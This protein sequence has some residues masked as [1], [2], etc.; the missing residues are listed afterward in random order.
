MRDLVEIPGHY[1]RM[2]RD[3]LAALYSHH[4]LFHG[5]V[6][7][8]LAYSVDGHFHLSGTVH[9]TRKGIG[10]SHTEIIVAVGGDD[11][12]V[13]IRH[14][15]AEILYLRAVFAWKAI[16]CRVGDVDDCSSGLNHSLND[17]G[18]VLVFR[19]S[20]IFRIELHVFH[21]FFRILHCCDRPFEDILTVRIELVPDMVVGRADS[22]VDSLQ[23]GEVQGIGR[24]IYILLDSPGQCA[25][26]GFRHYL[27]DFHDGFEIT[28]TRN[29]ETALDDIHLHGF[30]LLGQFYLLYRIQL[31]AGN[32]FAV[33]QCSVKDIKFLIHDYPFLVRYPSLSAV[34][35]MI[36]D[37]VSGN[38][39]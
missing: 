16:S 8:P 25:N 6:S 10:G 1:V 13:D 17:T 24:G 23:P 34:P 3:I 35:A 29:R 38:G 2:H 33:P 19:P 22:R 28:G 37:A 14:M 32:L 30:K 21:I 9:D 39:S 15:V 31:T 20:G 26:G 27:R 7:G 36:P 4:D 12:L 11:G 5:S 18:K